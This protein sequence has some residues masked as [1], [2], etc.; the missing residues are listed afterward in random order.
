MTGGT[1]QAHGISG[2]VARTGVVGIAATPE[3]RSKRDVRGDSLIITFKITDKRYPH[4]GIPLN[5]EETNGSKKK[6]V[7]TSH[8]PYNVTVLLKVLCYYDM[9]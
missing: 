5:D 8:G 6:R 7:T 9:Q 3:T 2:M 1:K 4:S